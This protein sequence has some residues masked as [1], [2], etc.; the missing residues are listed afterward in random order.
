MKRPE[1]KVVGLKFKVKCGVYILC[2]TLHSVKLF[3]LVAFSNEAFVVPLERLLIDSL[4]LYTSLSSVL[5]LTHVVSVYL[6]LSHLVVVLCASV[7]T[8]TQEVDVIS[9]KNIL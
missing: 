9:S 6:V 2:M 4:L 3:T 1:R 7:L 5:I 8:V